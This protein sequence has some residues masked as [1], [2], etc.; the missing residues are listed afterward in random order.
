VHVD[1]M[2][3]LVSWLA[4]RDSE[5]NVLHILNVAGR[6]GSLSIQQCAEIAHSKIVRVPKRVGGL[7]L[8]KLWEWGISSIPPEALPYMIGSYTMNTS[9]LQQLLGSEYD[10][11]MKYTVE[12]A[13]ADSFREATAAGASA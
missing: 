4:R 11:V 12:D 6:G 5:G 2:A 13:L 3:R 8:R 7:V 10:Q 9:R 1:D